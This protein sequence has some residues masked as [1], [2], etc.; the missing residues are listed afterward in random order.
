MP[1]DHEITKIFSC[2]KLLRSV[3]AINKGDCFAIG[4]MET[5]IEAEAGGRKSEVSNQSEV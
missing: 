2:D 5:P 3:T 4:D 1:P